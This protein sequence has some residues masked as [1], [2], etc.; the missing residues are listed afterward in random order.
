MAEHIHWAEDLA[1][2]ALEKKPQPI[3]ITSGMTTSGPAHLG[4][5]SEFLYPSAVHKFLISKGHASD[6]IFMADILDAFDSV[7]LSHS[8][9]DAQLSPHLGKPLCAVPDP[10]GCHDSFGEH[11]LAEAQGIMAQFGISPDIRRANEMYASGAFDA[12]TDFFMK[13]K[14]DAAR[15][16]AESAGREL[17]KHWSPL[18]PICEKCGKIATTR[19]TS[20]A[21]GAYEYVD[22]LDVKYAHGCGH[23]GHGK[24]PDHKYK[25]TW[26]LHWPAWMEVF[27]T[28]LEGAGVDH[29]TKGGS[30]DTAVAVFR[31]LFKKEP[32]I[33]F[34]FGFV[35][36]HGKKYS[37]S[38][39]TGMGVHELLQ[40]LPPQVI[41]FHLLRPDL[42]ENRDIAPTKENLPRY[43]EEYETASKIWGAMPKVP[44]TPKTEDSIS[45]ADR[46]R[47][48]AYSLAGAPRQWSCEFADILIYY[49]LYR[50]W[51]LTAAKLGDATGVTFLQKYIECWE[52]KNLIP[53]VYAIQYSPSTPESAPARDFFSLLT[54]AMDAKAIH[55]LVFEVA[56][57]HNVPA[58]DLFALLYHCLIGKQKGPKLGRLVEI[59]GVSRVKKDVLGK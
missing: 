49:S 40:I 18:M 22:D 54:P 43:I 28:S 45:R 14:E 23:T 41:A 16:V 48:L 5:L 58:A 24:L 9:F 44:E 31:Q 2:E 35:L 15:V 1:L 30:W 56:K 53:E 20:Y 34:K 37:K 7:P 36:F 21:D 10:E 32:P 17:P 59:L 52:E 26:R 13:N 11:F 39:G 42:A 27:H 51:G 25:L 4:T 46:K 29:H 12:L 6:F 57:S 50:D 47:A 38:K 55:N 8:R 19:V 3:I 33:G